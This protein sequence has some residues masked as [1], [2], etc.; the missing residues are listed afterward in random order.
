M[1]DS[2][3][4]QLL[5]MAWTKAQPAVAAF[6]TSMVGDFH[7]SEDL[8][9]KTAAAIVIKYDTYDASRSFT[10]WA[11]TAAPR[12]GIVTSLTTTSSPLSPTPSPPSSRSWTP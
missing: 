8:L 6:I 9:Q 12:R 4:M 5:A 2:Q 1:Q 7:Q 11:H 10:A 3:R